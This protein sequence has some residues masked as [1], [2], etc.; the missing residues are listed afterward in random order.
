LDLPPRWRIHPVISIA[1]LELAPPG[2]DPFNRPKPDVQEPV[3]ERE[4]DS[5]EWKSWELERLVDKRVVKYG[6]KKCIEYLV[7]FKGYGNQWNDW[8]PITLLDNAKDLVQDYEQR[9]SE[10]L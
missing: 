8:Y 3:E 7:K 5:D 10:V 2:E 4:G 1:H 9:Q 6:G